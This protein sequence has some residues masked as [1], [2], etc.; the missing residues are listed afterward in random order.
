MKQ[1]WWS[2]QIFIGLHFD[3]LLISANI[4]LTLVDFILTMS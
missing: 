2:L 1:I 4:A 3:E